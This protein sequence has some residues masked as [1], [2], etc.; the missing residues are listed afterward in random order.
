M[1]YALVCYHLFK[2]R[3]KYFCVK[4]KPN[5]REVDTVLLELFFIAESVSSAYLRKPRYPGTNTVDTVSKPALVHFLL[6]AD[7]RS[8]TYDA[9]IPTKNVEELRQLVKTAPSQ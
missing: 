1:P 8:R 7:Q 4:S 2:R 5:I 3:K 6:L 9:H